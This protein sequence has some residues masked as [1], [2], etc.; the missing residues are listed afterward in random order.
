MLYLIAL[1]PA[2]AGASLWAINSRVVWWEWCASASAGFLATAI[3]HVCLVAGMT[4]DHETW[5]GRITTATHHP[6]WKATWTQTE[7]Y[8]DSKG[9]RHTRIVKK[10]R[11]YPEHWTASLSFGSDMSD[12]KRIDQELFQRIAVAFGSQ[13]KPTKPYKAHLVAGDPNDYVAENTTNYTFPATTSMR[14]ENRVKAA[15]SVFSYVKVPEGAGTLPYPAN[16]DWAKSDRLLGTAVDIGIREWDVLNSELGPR[17]FVNLIAVGF[18]P[19]ASSE[20]GQ[21]QEAAWVGGKKNDVV[22]C[23]GGGTRQKPSWTYCF[24]WTEEEIVKRNM[25]S[26]FLAGPIDQSIVP[27]VKEEMLVNYQIKDWSK[28]DYITIEPPGWSI[29]VLIAIMALAQAAFW[30]WALNNMEDKDS[31]GLQKLRKIRSIRA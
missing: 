11:E 22:V 4:S 28:F 29:A 5:S 2:L 17:S 9:K 14:F 13:I 31:L 10:T 27:K 7:T 25:E 23:Y 18:G 21:L 30:W 16:H 12:S 15:P 26:M 8:T 24:G 1:L 20:M 19:D 6:W 3:F